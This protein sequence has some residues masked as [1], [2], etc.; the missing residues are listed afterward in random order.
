MDDGNGDSQGKDIDD[1]DTDYIHV[2][3][4]DNDWRFKNLSY[5]PVCHQI[6]PGVQRSDSLW[7]QS[8]NQPQQCGLDTSYEEVSTYYN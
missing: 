7:I 3:A 8:W 1:G 4:N 2:T 6:T 5:L